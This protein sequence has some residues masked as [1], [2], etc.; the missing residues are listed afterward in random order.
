MEKKIT[1]KDRFNQLLAIDEVSMNDELVAFIQHEI[2]LL[3]KKAGKSGSTKQQK[4]NEEIMA[5]L[6]TELSEIGQAVTISDFQKKSE[7]ASMFSNQKISAL[8]RNMIKNGEIEKT[9][10]KGKSY[11]SA[12]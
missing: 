2:E 1:K 6:L 7:Y 10:E 8:F 3:E 9:T 12:I 11:F 5:N 4:E